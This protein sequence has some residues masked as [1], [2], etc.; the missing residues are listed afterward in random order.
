[1][2]VNAA[3]QLGT[4]TAAAADVA[5]QPLSAADGRRLLAELRRQQRQLALQAKEIAQLSAKLKMGG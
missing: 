1:M 2:V 4:A 3:G 5:S